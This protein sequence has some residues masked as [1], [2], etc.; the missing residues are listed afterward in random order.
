MLRKAVRAFVE[1]EVVPH[2]AVW[3]EARHSSWNRMRAGYLT[4]GA[5]SVRNEAN[6]VS[7]VTAGAPRS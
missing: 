5:R 6:G 3:E 2:V 7:S 4:R 1:R